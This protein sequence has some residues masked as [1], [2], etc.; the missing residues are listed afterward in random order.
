MK[1]YKTLNP[2]SIVEQEYSDTLHDNS[3]CKVKITK[4][5]IELADLLRYKGEIETNDVYLGSS[6]IGIISETEPNFFGLE[7]GKRVYIDPYR[8]CDECYNCKNGEHLKCSNLLSAGEDFNG[9]LANF[10]SCDTNKV[11]LLPD[12][13]S[14]LDALFVGHIALALTIIDKLNVQKGDYVV[15]TGG[16]TLAN[17]LSQ[18]IIYYQAVPIYLSTSD[19]ETTLAKNSGIYYVLDG[20]DNWIKEVS[21]ITGGRMAEKVVFCSDSSITAAKIFTLV[22]YNATVIFTGVYHN[23]TSFSFVKAIKKQS[24]ILCVNNGFGN[25]A[26]AI[27]LL[28]NK[29]VSL[30]H[31]NVPICKY[32]EVPT[33]FKKL[34]DEFDKTGCFMETLVE[35]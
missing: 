20:N 23:T 7:K 4:A 29:A 8:Q 31:F 3:A 27:N 6:G 11:Y 18:L 24:N 9:Y 35:I 5:L 34:N 28:A 14:D 19:S 1:G 25:T 21:T 2:L 17:I 15:V 13:V 22:S 12:S 32:D 26:A 16:N 10:T 33:Q 30:S